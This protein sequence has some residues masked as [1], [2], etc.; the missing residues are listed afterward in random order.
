MLAAV[1]SGIDNHLDDFELGIKATVSSEKIDQMTWLLS[2]SCAACNGIKEDLRPNPIQSRH[3]TPFSGRDF[4]PC[5]RMIVLEEFCFQDT[6][7][8][9]QTNRVITALIVQ[10][11]IML[12]KMKSP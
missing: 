10:I 2:Y 11:R 7:A 6:V 12:T 8:R 1:G 9:W 4:P 3:L 5:M